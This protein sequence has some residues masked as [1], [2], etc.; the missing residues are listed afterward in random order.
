MK[1]NLKNLYD[2]C[3]KN[4]DLP[5]IAMVDSDIVAEDGSMRWMA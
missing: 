2:L 5:V 3:K 4:P 1:E